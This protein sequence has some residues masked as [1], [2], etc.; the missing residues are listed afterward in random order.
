MAVYDTFIKKAVN[1]SINTFI[2]KDIY[3]L[4]NNL[5]ERTITHKLAEYL[6]YEFGSFY[7]VDC[8]Y[9]RNH[10]DPGLVKKIHITESIERMYKD[11]SITELINDDSFREVS[12]YPDIII[13]KRGNKKNLLAVEVKKSN[14][15]VDK[16]YDFRKLE[17]YTDQ[18]ELNNLHYEYGLYIEFN[19][20]DYQNHKQVWFKNGRSH[21]SV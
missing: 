14:S 5:G 15:R 7:S 20:N 13:H 17:A 1:S 18:S 10:L 3:L 12:V 4:E 11:K 2:M 8:E 9:N 16:A 6:Q 19:M 21:E